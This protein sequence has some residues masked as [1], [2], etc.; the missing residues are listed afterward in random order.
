MATKSTGS[1]GGFFVLLAHPK[2]K[3]QTSMNGIIL[4]IANLQN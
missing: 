4:S 2:A 3:R 1:G